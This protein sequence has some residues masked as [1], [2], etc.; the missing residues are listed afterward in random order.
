MKEERITQAGS[1]SGSDAAAKNLL[2][3]CLCSGEPRAQIPSPRAQQEVHGA[4]VRETANLQTQSIHISDRVEH[5]HLS[6]R[7]Q[8][9]AALSGFIWPHPSASVQQNCE[10]PD[11][12]SFD[13][14]RGGGGGDVDKCCVQKEMGAFFRCVCHKRMA[15]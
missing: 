14:S 10:T 11:R 4:P 3:I 1:G 5:T 15:E 9:P 2:L 12:N 13:L 8:R 7:A 6:E